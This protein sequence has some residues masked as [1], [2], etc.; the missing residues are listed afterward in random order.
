[1]TVKVNWTFS[2]K[3]ID[4]E[5]ILLEFTNEDKKHELLLT[6]VEYVILWNCNS[7]LQ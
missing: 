3:W 7:T 5:H 4:D 6:T 1:M 2:T